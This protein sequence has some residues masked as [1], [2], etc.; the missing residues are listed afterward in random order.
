[1]GED[2]ANRELLFL[3]TAPVRPR[4]RQAA[5]VFVLLSLVVCAAAVRYAALDWPQIPAFIPAYE[6][7]LVICDL[8]TAVLLLGQFREV[9]TRSL[10]ILGSG[11]LFTA[12]MALAHALSFPGLFAPQGL[13]GDS[14]TTV[15]LYIQWHAVFPL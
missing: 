9:R 14:Q 8:I 12:L 1:M 11:Y 6:A 13:F 5:V 4:D 7:A 10:L 15:W 2:A 3:S